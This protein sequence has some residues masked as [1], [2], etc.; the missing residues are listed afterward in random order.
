VGDWDEAGLVTRRTGLIR[1]PRRLA[2]VVL[3][4]GV[5]GALA[6]PAWADEGPSVSDL[7]QLS[8]EELGE[9]QVSSVSKH[10]ESLAEAPAAVYVIT[11]ED[12]RR[13]GATSLP[14]A[15]RLAP[16]LDVA[17]L[18]TSA[19]TITARGFN[20]PESAN[21]LLVLIDGRSVYTPLASTVFWE[22]VGVLLSD[23]D[24]IEVVS[25]PGGTL[26]GA[27]AVNGVI[28]IITRKANETQGFHAEGGVGDTDRLA[29]VRYGGQVGGVFLRVY[30]QVRRSDFG[31]QGFGSGEAPYTALQGG[32]R[33]DRAAGADGY[34]LQ[35]DVYRNTT[36]LIDQRFSGGDLL[37]RWRRDL[38]NGSFELQAYYDGF[39]R[40]YLVG[41]EALD[42]FDVQGQHDFQL[43]ERHR[44][45]WGGEYRIWR[46]RFDSFVALGFADPT[47][48]LNLGNLFAQDEI[49]L[50]PDLKL[51]LG[52]KLED[53][54]YSGLDWLP[55]ARLAWR[56]DERV[57]LWSSVSRAVRTPSRIDRELSGGGFLGASPDFKSEVVTAYEAGF[58]GQPLPG[59]S[60]SVSG[61]YNVYDD[62]RTTELIN[63]VAF[64][65]FLGNDLGG[66]TYGMEA[67]A[68]YAVAPWWRLSAGLAT[69]HKDL[70]VKPG[71]IDFS[72]MQEAGQDPHYHASLRSE[73][74]LSDRLELDAQ[75]R[76][77][78]H[79]EPSNVPAYVEA[80]VRIG[81]RLN[82]EM[83][84][85]LSGFN[86]LHSSHL[87]VIDPATSPV[88]RIPRSV[89]LSLTWAR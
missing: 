85:S 24:R 14:E 7:G 30:G 12:I 38:D 3:A 46:S 57:L 1:R 44:I 9:I 32:F 74:N 25:G 87:E 23:I 18:N 34:T 67:W 4:L 37:G 11:A 58:R 86:L 63:N 39:R 13:S 54:S 2:G 60:L 31:G 79:V 53:N 65:A 55:T 68:K 69:L 5:A 70:A 28:N 51:T 84:I 83:R 49:A 75:L 50:R 52:M 56:P 59:L 41:S 26:W 71:V 33:M 6:A 82:D 66:H 16:N 89:F 35:G 45:V 81:W 64:P 62:L 77:V 10:D 19:Y 42:T 27:N 8:L 73:M 29:A 78:G 22:S 61:F 48:T 80:D 36:E 72:N 20:S 43:G 17:R 15:L 88:T 21:K 40:D 76:S 47:A